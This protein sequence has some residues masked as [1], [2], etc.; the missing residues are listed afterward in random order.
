MENT[1]YSV[2]LQD[3][4]MGTPMSNA[5]HNVDDFGN[6]SLQ[7]RCTV[8][9]ISANQH[10]IDQCSGLRRVRKYFFLWGKLMT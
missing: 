4:I 9:S 10:K 3:K 2:S 8:Q 7:I 5:G 1:G 6:E